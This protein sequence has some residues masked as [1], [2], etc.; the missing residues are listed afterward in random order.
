ML[1]YFPK[2]SIC[3]E[4]GVLTGDFSA[5]IIARTQP[6]E[7]HLIDI[8]KKSLRSVE[9]RFAR[10]RSEGR[11]H[12]HLGNS[13][14]VLYSLPPEY[15]D[16]VY[17]DADHTYNAVK[18]DLEAARQAVKPNGLIALNDYIYFSP[19]DFSKYGVV[20]A[21]NEFCIHHDFEFVYLALQGRTY[22]DVVLRRRSLAG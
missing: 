20:E 11:V 16:W 2:N 15:F 12:V 7:L 6:A 1:E 14:D 17:I 13:A 8:S 18:R 4:L 21:V 9:E 22:Y 19:S 10:E 3:A 5:L